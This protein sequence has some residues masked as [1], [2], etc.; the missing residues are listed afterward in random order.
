MDA[1]STH[2]AG[3]APRKGDRIEI[4]RSGVA[5]RGTVQFVSD[6]QILVKWDDGSSGGLRIGRHE[7]RVFSNRDDAASAA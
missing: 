4:R 2:G 5:R 1:E 6:L 3:P 7:Y